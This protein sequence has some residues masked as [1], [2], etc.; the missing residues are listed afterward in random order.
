MSQTSP[1]SQMGL[2]AARI[3]IPGDKLLDL[4]ELPVVA[5]AVQS[6]A[7]NP[8]WHPRSIWEGVG[9]PTIWIDMP[10]GEGTADIEKLELELEKAREAA[11]RGDGQVVPERMGHP[12]MAGRLR[13][14]EQIGRRRLD[15]IKRVQYL[16]Q[17]HYAE[18]QSMHEVQELLRDEMKRSEGS[19]L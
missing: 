12:M 17:N 10:L 1:L 7:K 16:M 2:A 3:G 19:E 9:R 13:K 15:V 18:P 4:L 11:T 6:A 5:H 14:A 8:N